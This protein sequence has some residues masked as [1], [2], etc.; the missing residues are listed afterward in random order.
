[1]CRFFRLQA[2]LKKMD[3]RLLGEK[4]RNRA[5]GMLIKLLREELVKGADCE[6]VDGPEDLPPPTV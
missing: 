6:V 5:Q 1:M 3:Q 2:R 4:D